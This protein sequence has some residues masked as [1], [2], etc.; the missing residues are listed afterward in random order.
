MIAAGQ[1]GGY[2]RKARR[3]VRDVDEWEFRTIC[4]P[5]GDRRQ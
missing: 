4:K 2:V 1:G 3:S 5:L